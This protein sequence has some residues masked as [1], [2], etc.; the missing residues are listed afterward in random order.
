MKLNLFILIFANVVIIG[1]QQQSEPIDA[2]AIDTTNLPSISSKPIIAKKIDE[3]KNTSIFEVEVKGVRSDA[4]FNKY[5]IVETRNNSKKDI[6]AFSFRL[7]YD[8]C[9]VKIDKKL[10]IKSFQ[11]IKIKVKL[12]K[13]CSVL[14]TS[15]EPTEVVYRDGIFFNRPI[16]F[17]MNPSENPNH[18][19]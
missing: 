10:E 9:S 15:A 3:N 14:K 17:I 7:S 5:A 4:D 2:N 18:K 12:S 13:G 16:D 8:S 6:I 1:C 19:N 11:S